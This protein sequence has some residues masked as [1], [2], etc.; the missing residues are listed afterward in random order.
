MKKLIIIACMLSLAFTTFGQAQ[1]QVWKQIN[2]LTDTIQDKAVVDSTVKVV[3]TQKDSIRSLHQQAHLERIKAA[4]KLSEEHRAWLYGRDAKGN[5]IDPWFYLAALIIAMLSWFVSHFITVKNGIKEN[6]TSPPK[7]SLLYWW[8]DNKARIFR[9]IAIL[10]FIL[11]IC[12]LSN[13][14]LNSSL[15]FLYAVT[16]GAGLDQMIEIYN[17]YTQKK[18]DEIKKT[19][20]IED[21]PV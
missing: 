6:K 13:E 14:I 8:I 19:L 17:R 20:G 3:D 21:K 15:N 5:I 7:F 2:P 11:F 12:R 10:I 16:L 18:L 9:M 4:I 1:K